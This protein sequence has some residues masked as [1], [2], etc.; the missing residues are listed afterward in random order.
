MKAKENPF[1]SSAVA[2]LRYRISAAELARLVDTL[3]AQQWRAC[4]TGPEG[5]GKSALLEALEAPISE[6]GRKVHWIRLNANSS[7][8]ERR[9]A[10]KRLAR[11]RADEVCLIDGGEVFGRLSWLRIIRSLKCTN[12][13][14]VATVHRPCGLPAL[15]ETEA[16]LDLAL[17]LSRDLAGPHWNEQL[18]AATTDSFRASGGNIREVF[19]AGYWQCARSS[20][21]PA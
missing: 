21:Q 2:E 9:E 19:R 17:S 12:A 14:I 11:L 8:D 5:S 7:P 1:R 3:R 16:S 20:E 13:G 4:L 6:A 15:L 18:E 10:R